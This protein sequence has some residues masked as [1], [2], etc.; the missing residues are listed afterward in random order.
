[1]PRE[2]R[3]LRRCHGKCR[4][5]G[6]TCA[7]AAVNAE[8][9]AQPAPM[10]RQMPR[11]RRNLRRCRGK[12][13]ES[14]ATCADATANAGIA[15]QPCAIALTYFLASSRRSHQIRKRPASCLMEVLVRP[16]SRYLIAPFRTRRGD[17]FAI[18]HIKKYPPAELLRDAK[19][20]LLFRSCLGGTCSTQFRSCPRG[21]VAASI[22]WHPSTGR[23]RFRRRS[24]PYR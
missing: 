22:N 23:L 4:E 17:L 18:P 5:S 19:R 15:A 3:N 24:F 16:N 12:C 21:A 1:M 8:R 20:V 7:D 14:G 13:R 9:A 6:A 2:R 10:P 11:E